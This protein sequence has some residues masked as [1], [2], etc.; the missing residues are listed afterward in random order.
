MEN[1]VS[2]TERSSGSFWE[3]DLIANEDNNESKLAAQSEFIKQFGPAHKHGCVITTNDL[4]D[5][6]FDIN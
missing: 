6:D 2:K 4:F 1:I 5:L 3:D